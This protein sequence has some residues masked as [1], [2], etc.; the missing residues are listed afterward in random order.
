MAR[1]TPEERRKLE[2]LNG[3][4]GRKNSGSVRNRKPVRKK[5]SGKGKLLVALIGLIALGVLI[6]LMVNVFQL[7]ARYP[8]SSAIN[9]MTVSENKVTLQATTDTYGNKLIPLDFFMNLGGGKISDINEKEKLI[10]FNNGKEMTIEEGSKRVAVDGNKKK[11]NSP[12]MTIGERI[13]VPGEL[14]EPIFGEKA[15]FVDGLATFNIKE[16]TG[17]DKFVNFTGGEGY[18][19][20]VN[21]E[22]ILPKDFQPKDLIEVNTLNSIGAY[23]DNTKMRKKAADALAKMY[24]ASDTNM[25]LSSG[26]RTYESQEKLYNDEVQGEIDSGLSEKEAKAE[27]GSR[28]ALPGSSEHQLGLVADI[29]VPGEI[30]TEDF[31]NTEAGQWLKKNSYKYGYILRYPE[32]KQ[33]TTQVIYEPWHYRY[34]GLPHSEI[35]TKKDITFD[36]YIMDLR[37]DRSLLYTTEDKNNYAIWYFNENEKPENI[38][39]T[40]KNGVDVST[41]NGGGVIVTIPL[42]Q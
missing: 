4:S 13:W 11:Y 27:A 15:S 3:R 30:L 1:M 5:K 38:Q 24:D 37:K 33:I 18:L 36:E 21:Q 10:V 12:V 35:V 32:N 16:S 2:R 40:N 29:A 9:D 42:G 19:A 7:P 17:E 23:G 20:L 34:I 25:I 31:K 22:N 26:F 39:F 8:Q 14:L 41:D 28:V 6:Y